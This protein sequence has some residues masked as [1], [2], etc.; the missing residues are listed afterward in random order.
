[1]LSFCSTENEF[2]LEKCAKDVAI[3]PVSL[4]NEKESIKD[5]WVFM[6][7][8]V[9]GRHNFENKHQIKLVYDFSRKI[10]SEIECPLNTLCDGLKFMK[11]CC[12]QI[13]NFQ[14]IKYEL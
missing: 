10:V 4:G 9:F 13:N 8:C 14:K 7:M 2:N 1:M 12:K 3:V 6:L 11:R 5:G